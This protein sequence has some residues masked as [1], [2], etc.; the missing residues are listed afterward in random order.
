MTGTGLDWTRKYP[1]ITEAVAA[2][3]APGLS[4][5]RTVG[6][7]L[8]GITS[9][10]LIQAASDAGNAAALAYSLRPLAS[11]CRGVGGWLLSK[12]RGKR[13]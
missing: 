3:G 10:S 9:F 11:G 8:D 5:R 4:R 12:F 7:F 2:L 6:V 1:A 13:A